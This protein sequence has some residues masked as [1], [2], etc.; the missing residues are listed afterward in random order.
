MREPRKQAR[1]VYLS[2]IH[3]DT[4]YLKQI[5]PDFKTMYFET[6]VFKHM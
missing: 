1:F 4:M 2:Q 5:T 3:L 6:R